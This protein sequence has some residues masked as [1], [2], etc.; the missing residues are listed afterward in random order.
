MSNIQLWSGPSGITISNSAKEPR[1]IIHYATHLSPRQQLDIVRAFE[2][3]AYEMAAEYTWKKAMVKLKDTLSTLGLKFIGEMLG[4]SDIQEN[5][6][7]ESILTDYN[8]IQLAEQLGVVGNTAALRLKQSNE[9]ITHFFSKNTDEELNYNDALGIVR[10]SVQYILGEGEISV[11]IEFSD[12]RNRLLSS[13]IKQEDQSIDQLVNS[14]LFYI[15]TVLTVILT[16]AREESGAKLEHAL[17][18]LNMMIS[19]IWDKISESDRWSIGE[20]YR[21]VV[22]SGNQA[23]ASGLKKALSKVRGFDYVPESLR[24]TTFKNLAKEVIDIHYSYDNFYNEPAVVKKLAALGS[25]IPVPALAE[26]MQAYLAVFLGNRYGV[27]HK[28]LEIA[29]EQLSI[30][31]KDRWK[32]YFDKIIQNDEIV[33]SKFETIEQVKRFRILLIDNRLDDFE[34]FSK[35]VSDLY[36]AILSGNLAKSK[37][38]SEVLYSKMKYIE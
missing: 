2:A 33:L 36:K 21:D 30:I 16:A 5:L 18:N 17:G 24:S 28:A 7:I 13:T 19:R 9:L 8:A 35:P 37:A 12:F 11:A 26:C 4:R 10:T 15:R 25:V 32:Y 3:E 31:T 34:G 20:A 23:T 27:S 6:P 22:A 38:A 1:E 14:P 29:K